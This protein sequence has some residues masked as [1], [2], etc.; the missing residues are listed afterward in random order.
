MFSKSNPLASLL[1][2][3]HKVAVIRTRR[4]KTALDTTTKMDIPITSTPPSSGSR[5]GDIVYIVSEAIIIRL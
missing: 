1:H 5:S 4:N 2:V 3:M